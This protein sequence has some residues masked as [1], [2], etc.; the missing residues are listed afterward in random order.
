MSVHDDLL[1]VLKQLKLSGVLQSLDVRRT[2]ASEQSLSL[3]EFLYFVLHDEVERR[4]AKRL[5][6][7]THRASFEE[8]KTLEDFDFTFNP[9][10]PRSQILE[11]GTC[12]WVQRRENVILVGAAGVGKSHLAQALGLRAC[13]AGHSVQF[14]SANDMLVALR[15]ARADDTVERRLLKYTAPDVLIIDDLG[16]RPLRGDEPLDL[17]EVIRRR[18]ERNSTVITSNRATEEWSPLFGDPLLASAACDRVLHHAHVIEIDG[19]SYRSKRGRRPT[20]G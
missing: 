3:T 4:N 6:Q 20:A 18:Y 1:P 13:R 8:I 12:A 15:A 9:A 2:Q 16:L 11:L 5:Q 17:F 14:T 10:I 7:R 19:D